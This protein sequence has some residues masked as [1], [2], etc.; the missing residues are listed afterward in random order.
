MNIYRKKAPRFELEGA[1]WNLVEGRAVALV[2]RSEWLKD[3]AKSSPA[4][5]PGEAQIKDLHDSLDQC[6]LNRERITSQSKEPSPTI[7]ETSIFGFI[8]HFHTQPSVSDRF[9]R[10]TIFMIWHPLLGWSFMWPINWC[11][12]MPSGHAVDNVGQQ[13]DEQRHVEFFSTHATPHH[14]A[15]YLPA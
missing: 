6:P 11:I 12:I 10:C 14:L 5:A 15:T 3:V 13:T 7:H 2:I 9:Q 8:E 1:P 4:I